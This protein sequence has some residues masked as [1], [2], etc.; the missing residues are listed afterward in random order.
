MPRDCQILAI[1]EVPRNAVAK[2]G[3]CQCLRSPILHR[4]GQQVELTQPRPQGC[5]M[6]HSEMGP[7]R[8]SGHPAQTLKINHD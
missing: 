1:P 7:E 6:T 2:R 3:G 5:Q 4:P 8:G